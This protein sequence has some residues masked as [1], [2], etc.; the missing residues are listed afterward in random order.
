M[1]V[2]NVTADGYC[3]VLEMSNG[4]KV[5]CR[6]MPPM[7]LKAFERNHQLP[8]PPV[9]QVE[10]LKGHMDPIE[11]ESDP[12]YQLELVAFEQRRAM[13]F[14]VLAYDYI[15]LLDEDEQEA[16]DRAERLERYGMVGDEADRLECFAL[17]EPEQDIKVLTE[18][19]MRLS[20]V[21][22]QEVV[23][24]TDS[25]RTPM[26][27]NAGDETQDAEESPDVRGDEAIPVP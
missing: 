13:D 25:F 18:E 16:Q 27:G 1:L 8:S 23:K 4:A 22:M 3:S 6:R 15:L 12:D 14:L 5:L 7:L 2:S 11:D 17:D 24:Q 19:I 20:T 10:T 26:D 21:T 9:K